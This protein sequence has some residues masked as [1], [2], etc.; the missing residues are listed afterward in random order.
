MFICVEIVSDNSKGLNMGAA[1]NIIL[2]ENGHEMFKTESRMALDYYDFMEPVLEQA[3][4][5]FCPYCGARAKYEFVHYDGDITDCSTVKTRGFHREVMNRASQAFQT[6]T[7][8][9]VS[10]WDIIPHTVPEENLIRR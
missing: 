3:K 7:P 2:C 6:L 10:V 8:E 1:G 4:Q 5:S 9:V